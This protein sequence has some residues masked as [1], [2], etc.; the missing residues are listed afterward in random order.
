M[1]L[2]PALEVLRLIWSLNHALEVTSKRMA[3][4]LGITAQQRMVVRI[5]G[6][7]PGITAGGL[8]ELLRVH[9]GTVS[10]ALNRL[11]KRALVKRRQDARDQRRVTLTLTRQG[12]ALDVARA[13]T[14]ESAVEH[15]LATL[16]SEDL[17]GTERLVAALV[18]ALERGR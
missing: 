7:Y 5:I 6:K 11:E 17:G 12:R 8:A 10:V 3:S 14:V 16:S 9:R 18:A 13:G 1:E 2:G 4:E 15:V